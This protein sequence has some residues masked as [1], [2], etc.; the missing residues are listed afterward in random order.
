MQPG[1]H[2]GRLIQLDG[3][4][5]IAAIAVMLFH[6]GTVFGIS[7]PFSRSYLFV[8]MFFVLSGFVLT[9]VAEP[10]MAKGQT[11]LGFLAARVKRLWPTIA[12]GALIGA[13]VMGSTEGWS[14]VPLLLVMA[15][16]MIP[17]F[18]MSWQ[19]FPL[20]G[21]QWSLF[22]EIVANIAHAFLLRYLGDRTLLAVALVSGALLAWTILH[23]GANGL[24]PDAG[25]F[26]WSFPR[27]AFSYT[28]GI[29]FGRKFAK[30]QYKP[31]LSWSAALI[32]PIA[33][34]MSLRYLPISRPVGDMLVTI[35]VFPALFWACALATPPASVHRVLEKLGALSF[36]LYA[37]HLPL[38]LWTASF[39]KSGWFAVCGIAVSLLAAQAMAVATEAFSAR[40]SRQRRAARAAA[41]A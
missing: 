22:H 15:L 33:V 21:P 10:R 29:W 23:F 12:V 13:A 32:G 39:D 26:A 7:T 8:D 11:G 38:L 27:I 5:G 25:N 14:D 35:F 3:L 31:I 36:P 19:V 20:N 30:G 24:G 6:V 17:T 18:T 40:K 9:L 34:A 1:A 16:A 28:I 2:A 4:R 41:T 37:V